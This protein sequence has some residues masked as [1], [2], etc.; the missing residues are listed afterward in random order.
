M[1]KGNSE[2]WH[3]GPPFPHR[4]NRV[5][6][7]NFINVCNFMQYFVNDFAL[8][9]HPKLWEKLFHP[10]HFKYFQKIQLNHDLNIKPVV[11]IC[12]SGWTNTFRK[13][14]TFSSSKQSVLSPE[15]RLLRSIYP[16]CFEKEFI[17]AYSRNLWKEHMKS[18][19]P[20]SC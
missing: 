18:I 12:F 11:N 15:R 6:L 7:S 3:S 14:Q 16:S 8:S 19:T 17:S 5:S 4:I 10:K 1:P 20:A 13:V 9:H 2:V